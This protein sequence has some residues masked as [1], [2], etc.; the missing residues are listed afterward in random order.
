MTAPFTLSRLVAAPIAAP[1]AAPMMAS[2]LVFFF[3]VVTSPPLDDDTVPP[4]VPDV[5]DDPDEARRVVVDLRAVDRVGV[6]A[7]VP[8]ATPGASAAPSPASVESS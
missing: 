7:V 6:R 1:A 5:P 3:T 2:R 4:D 8:V